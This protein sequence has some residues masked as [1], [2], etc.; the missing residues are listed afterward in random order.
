MKGHLNYGTVRGQ[1]D[2]HETLS[3]KRRRR[4]RK[5]VAA[6]VVEPLKTRVYS[7]GGGFHIFFLHLTTGPSTQLF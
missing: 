6:M 7:K 2:I 1:S 3:L 4:R 5:V